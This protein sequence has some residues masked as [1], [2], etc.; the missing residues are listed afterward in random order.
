MLRLVVVVL[1]LLTG[2]YSTSLLTT[3][4]PTPRGIL[5]VTP[6]VALRAPPPPGT[7]MSPDESTTPDFEV[8]ARLGLHERADLGIKAGLFHFDLNSLVLLARSEYV[9]FSALPGLGTAWMWESTPLVGIGGGSSEVALDTVETATRI[10]AFKLPLLV[11]LHDAKDRYGIFGG[12]GVQIGYRYCRSIARTVDAI[13]VDE[14]P[15]ETRRVQ[16][17]SGADRGAF[18]GVGAHLGIQFYAGRWLTL[19]PEVSL[20]KLVVAPRAREVVI[21]ETRTNVSHGDLLL[22]VA[23]GV[24]VSVPTRRARSP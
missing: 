7:G 1:L 3:P 6:S 15:L 24:Q 10:A 9:T 5:R 20:L 21:D 8:A 14:T 12:P 13:Y 17:C 22:Q 2:C 11:G 19:L 23:F 18:V 4:T 16:T